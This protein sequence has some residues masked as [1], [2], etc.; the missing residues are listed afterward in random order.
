MKKETSKLNLDFCTSFLM[1][2]SFRQ[3]SRKKK[4][5][6]SGGN[7]SVFP[8]FTGNYLWEKVGKIFAMALNALHKFN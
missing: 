5:K 6:R 8:V 7:G 4:K 3:F 1:K 2:V